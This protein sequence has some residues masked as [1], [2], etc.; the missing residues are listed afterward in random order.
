VPD[1]Q[2]YVDLA[3]RYARQNGVPEDLYAAQIN[4]ES[5]FNPTAKS[6]ADARGIAQIVPRWHPDV[7]PS[8]PGNQ[9][10]GVNAEWDLAYGARLMSSHFKKY[11]SWEKA[12]SAYNSGKPNAYLDPNFSKGQTYNY[13]KSILQTRKQFTGGKASRN[14]TFASDEQE[15]TNPDVTTS[16]GEQGQKALVQYLMAQNAAFSKGERAD[17]QLMTSFLL[18]NKVRE[19]QEQGLDGG[20][21][22]DDGINVEPPKVEGKPWEQVIG[23]IKYAQ[24]LGLRVSENPYVDKVDPV[25]VEGSDHY[26]TYAGTKVGKGIDVSGDPTK[27]KAYFKYLEKN[28]AGSLNDLFYTPMGYSYDRGKRWNQTIK[29]HTDHLH[30]SFF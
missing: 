24:S 5:R 22:D 25:H 1:R 26:K 18:A 20:T 10:P 3:K 30:G 15:A 29:N 27:L 2:H 4:Q 8:K 11:G 23:A 19:H 17:P 21:K 13:V 14:E 16:Q 12:L 9:L 28:Y 7:N 6:Y